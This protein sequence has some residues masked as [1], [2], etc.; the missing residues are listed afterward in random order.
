MSG[1]KIHQQEEHIMR[2]LRNQMTEAE[3][4]AFEWEMQRDPFLAEA[5][6]GFLN[7]DP[8]LIS[9]DLADIRKQ[10]QNPKRNRRIIWYA[11][12]SILILIVSSVV[13]FNMREN[14]ISSVS[15]NKIQEEVIPKVDST[16][17]QTEIKQSVAV[18][19]KKDLEK[20]EDSINNELVIEDA[21]TAY[22]ASKE[23]TNTAI[24]VVEKMTSYLSHSEIMKGKSDTLGVVRVSQAAPK[25]PSQVQL[26]LVDNLPDTGKSELSE[27][28]VVGY[29]TQK[30]TSVTG[31]VSSV[32]SKP[33]ADGKAYPKGGWKAFE[34]YLKTEL[35]NPKI[36]RPGKK[37]IVRLSFVVTES[38]EKM[39][40]NILRSED[41]LYS[42]E[43]IRIIIDG[44]GWVPEVK[45]KTRQ[46]SVVKLKLVFE[47]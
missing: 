32:K 4:H 27:V 31:A 43:A 9:D 15:E 7:T 33:L 3:R 41:E 2:Y 13:L 23:V 10:I 38:G 12:A 22:V 8:D 29:G 17:E 30:K 47:P 16:N 6:D 1:K 20:Q 44:P 11:A 5:V 24:P 14:L 40:F 25:A 21:E 42:N 36:G 39:H 18:V 26:N 28:V 37:T 35:S 46:S 45:E 19:P 34:E